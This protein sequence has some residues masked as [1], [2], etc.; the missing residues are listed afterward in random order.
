MKNS[1]RNRARKNQY[2]SAPTVSKYA[3]KQNVSNAAYVQYDAQIESSLE[4]EEWLDE[5]FG[6]ECLNCGAPL[7]HKHTC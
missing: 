2:K 7:G 1:K 5:N 4:H 6:N 3:A